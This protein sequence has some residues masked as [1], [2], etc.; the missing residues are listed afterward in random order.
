MKNGF[1]TLALSLLLGNT[2]IALLLSGASA[3][4]AQEA[5]PA[6]AAGQEAPP[7]PYDALEGYVPANTAVSP[8]GMGTGGTDIP[9][10]TAFPMTQPQ[11]PAMAQP[12]APV[13]VPPPYPMTS[14]DGMPAISTGNVLNTE[15]IDG[16]NEAIEGVFPMTP[17]MI[18]QYRRIFEENQRA[19]MERPEPQATSD[20]GIIS[21]E[22]GEESP[23]VNLAPGIASVVGFY[24]A[25]GQ[26]WPISQYVIGSGDQF[27]VIQLGKDANS[28]TITPLAAIGWTNLVIMLRDE[29]KPIVMRLAVN[30]ETAHYRRDIQVMRMG[31]NSVPNMA[32]PGPGGPGG[33]VISEA[34]N[35]VLLAALTGVDL[36]AGARPVNVSGVAA[37]AWLLDDTMFIRSQAP[38]LSPTWSNSMSGP[39]GVRVYEIP[40]SSV[41][42][43]SVDGTIVRADIALP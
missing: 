32:M 30:P 13:M 31:P 26:P 39:D 33:N 10:P 40:P 14:P 5:K 1:P 2:A 16:F 35:T 28:L 7:V 37:R 22:P 12:Q 17:D 19:V 20:A 11:A 36:P 34:G 9:P 3:V 42:L 38:L 24:D 18:R 4:Q 29:P 27:Q 23:S 41:A 21:L 6:P 8:R 15:K 43:F 25:S